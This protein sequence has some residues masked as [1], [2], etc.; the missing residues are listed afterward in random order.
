MGHLGNAE[1]KNW[2]NKQ[3]TC[4]KG[5]VGDSKVCHFRKGLMR[6]ANYKEL[7]KKKETS[8]EKNESNHHNLR[9][10]ERWPWSL[11]IIFHAGYLYFSILL[12]Q[13]E[14]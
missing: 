3:L 9:I 6:K 10:L 1:G 12:A 5:A 2:V 4:Q 14:L 8:D 11:E 7:I 13:F